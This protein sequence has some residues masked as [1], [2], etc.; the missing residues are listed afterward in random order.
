M[1]FAQGVNGRI[2]DLREAL[3]AVIP[4]RT[5]E[6]GHRSRRG[7]VAH[8]PD[9]FLSLLHQRLE[10]Q[11]ELVFAPAQSSHR[12]LRIGCPVQKRF[13]GGLDQHSRH[14]GDDPDSLPHAQRIFGADKLAAL[15]IDQQNFSRPQALPFG[16]LFAVEIGNSYLGAD[17]Q[18][19]IRRQGV[20]QGTQT[21][22]VQ[23]RADG[24]AVGE[25]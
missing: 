7:I 25:D 6:G 13:V 22:A 24:A 18:Q 12:W 8:A 23:L 4:Q 11:A 5:L 14:R 16:D 21:V 19:T 10:K 2:R 1:R 9:R 3:F 15:G 17:H 20:T